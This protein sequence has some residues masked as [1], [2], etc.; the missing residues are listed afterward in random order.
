MEIKDDKVL[1]TA[2]GGT[3]GMYTIVYSLKVYN[4]ENYR[5]AWP[6]TQWSCENIK[7][8]R[9]LVT[10]TFHCSIEQIHLYHTE[11]NKIVSGSL[12]S[13]GIADGDTIRAVF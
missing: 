11:G 4:C 7:S 5:T 10:D 9:K 6:V 2:G 8:V 13:N 3:A 12:V 1:E